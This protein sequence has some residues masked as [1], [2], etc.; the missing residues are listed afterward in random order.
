MFKCIAP[1]VLLRRYEKQSKSCSSQH[2][3]FNRLSCSIVADCTSEELKKFYKAQET[4]HGVNRDHP[5]SPGGSDLFTTKN[6][7][8][9]V[10]LGGCNGESLQFGSTNHV[11]A[12][13]NPNSIMYTRV[14][15]QNK[16]M[17]FAENHSEDNRGYSIGAQRTYS[18]CQVC[19]EVGSCSLVS[20]INN[21]NKKLDYLILNIKPKQNYSVNDLKILYSRSKKGKFIICTSLERASI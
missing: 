19:R 6:I 13:S 18:V 12:G 10:N 15:A 17:T 8:E 16:S 11:G 4:K 2:Q 3:G 5:C 14:D 20:S 9:N 1:L 7:L 21:L